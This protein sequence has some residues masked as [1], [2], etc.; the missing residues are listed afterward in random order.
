MRRRRI[1]SAIASPWANRTIGWATRRWST[2]AVLDALWSAGFTPVISPV[3]LDK[4]AEALNCNADTVAGA[5]AAELGAD[6]L[7]LLSD[8]DQLL[9]DVDDATI[10]DGDSL[11]RAEIELDAALRSR[12]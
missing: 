2:D 12:A 9:A 3:A 10:G 8:I 1:A 6:V 11:G 5:I 7:V 4:D